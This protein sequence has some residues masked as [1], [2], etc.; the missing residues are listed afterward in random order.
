MNQKITRR[1]F[2]A[3]LSLAALAALAGA[4]VWAQ[5]NKAMAIKTMPYPKTEKID[6][7]DTYFGTTVSD[8][9]RW[10]EDDRSA[11]T[12]AWVKAENAVTFAYLD[13]IP[14]RADLQKRLGEL[15]NYPRYSAP[16]QKNNTIFFYKNSGLQNQSVLYVQQGIDGTPEV[17]ID[18]NTLSA[19][20]T[21][22]LSGFALSHNGKY[23]AYL[24]SQ[25]GSDWQEM[26]VMEIASKK[27]LDDTIPWVKFSGASWRGDSGF[28]YSKYPQPAP[29]TELTAKNENQKVYWHELGTPSTTDKLV[30]EEP[31]HPDRSVSVGATED[32]KW[33]FLYVSEPGKRGNA[34]FF[35]P[36]SPAGNDLTEPFAPIVAEIGKDS[37]SAIDNDGDAFLIQTNADAPN[38]KIVK[39]TVGKP[40]MKTADVILPE[41][42]EAIS[43]IG[44]AGGKLFVSTL[45]DVTTRVQVYDYSG[46]KE[47][48]ITLPAPGSAGGFGG[49]KKDKSFFYTFTSY[50]Y[51]PAIFRYDIASGKS[52]L[53]RTAEIPNFVPDN[54]VVRQAFAPSK[55]GTRIPLFI[56]HKKGLKQNGQNPTLL[57]GYGG[58]N[59]SL[60]PSFS[61]LRLAWMEQGGVYVVANLRGGAE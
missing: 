58:F 49:E 8:P 30:Y 47:R 13:Q 31:A 42:K 3:T 53:F 52:S 6:H 15:I 14:Y 23:A 9:Y 33:E 48:E 38:D 26:H 28:Y 22:R 55:D 34:L 4:P 61:S 37:Y 51:P 5:D 32:E 21:A 29:G 50:N 44:T 46:K 60:T 17:L 12:E 24:I 2:A 7:T 18:P 20:G 1:T 41:G 39:I 43:G 19:D 25:A 36:A 35:R 16:F 27:V 11:Q 40:D 56:V 10:L 45:H 54:Y 59:I 57:Y